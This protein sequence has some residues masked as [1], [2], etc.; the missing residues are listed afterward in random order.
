[1]LGP[2]MRCVV[3]ID[4]AQQAHVVCA[5]E[6]TRGAVRHQSSRI[7]AIAAGYTVLRRWLQTWAEGG[8]PAAVL[9]G[10]EATGARW[11]PLY[12]TLAQAGY[13]V[14]LLHPRQTASRASSWGRRAKTA[15]MD[16]QTLARG[17]A[18]GWAR[19]STRPAATVPA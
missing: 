12:D 14:L 8:P 4:V 3:G 19:G 10:L 7:E 5:L 9:S 6:A 15:G 13:P 18:A 11:E 17:L 16:A 2:E 1:M